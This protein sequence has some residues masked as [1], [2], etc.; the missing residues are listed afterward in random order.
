VTTAAATGAHPLAEDLERILDRTRDLWPAL[1]GERLLLTGGTGFFG[2]WLLES[3]AWAVDRLALDSS[4]TVLTRDP[5][6]FRRKAPRLAAHPA[7]RLLP[8]DVRSFTFPPGGFPFVIHAA[9]EASD[10]LNRSDPALMLRTIVEGTARVLE[11]ARGAGTRGFLLAS[12]GAVYGRQPPGLPRLSEDS[13]GAPDPLDPGAAYGEGK[14]AAELL[15]AAEARRSGMSM[16]IARGFA[17]VGPY[18]PLDIHYAVG[19]FLRDA[20]AGGPI[21]VKGDGTPFRSYLYAADLALWLWTMLFRVSGVRAWNV[22][23][24]EAFSIAQ[25]ARAVAECAAPSSEVRILGTPV[26]GAP[27]ERYVPDT[28]RA[29][30]EL[31]LVPLVGLREAICRTLAWH[32]AGGAR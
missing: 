21:V 30:A 27:A 29:R 8:G 23:S 24:E 11:F 17:F 19:N 13:P 25:T 1:R 22:G 28:A 7:V 9:T 4:V 32:G 16:G 15:C 14:R 18:L 5:D 3:F 10:S 2:C 6:A 31:G 20:L 12:S 26:P